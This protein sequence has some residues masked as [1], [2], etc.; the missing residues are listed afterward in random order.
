LKFIVGNHEDLFDKNY[1]I[2]NKTK[3]EKKCGPNN[4]Q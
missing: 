4:L 1:R 3:K 2:K